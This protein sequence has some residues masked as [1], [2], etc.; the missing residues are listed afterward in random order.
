[1]MASPDAPVHASAVTV[2]GAGI[3]VR[4]ASG[5]GKSSLVL[6]ILHAEG[7]AACLVADDRMCL[8]RRGTV[9]VARPPREIA[10]L[11]EVRGQGV[12]RLPYVAEAPLALVVDLA[13]VEACPRY[14]E[15]DERVATILGVVLP[16]IWLAV[17][18]PDGPA[19]VA[20]ALATRHSGDSISAGTVLIRSTDGPS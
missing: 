2:R 16:R 13:P 6:S 19:R 3:L 20:F 5:A 8:A 17:G 15:G 11:I 1:M 10:G 4:G 9:V 18:A 12:L 14:P 7:D